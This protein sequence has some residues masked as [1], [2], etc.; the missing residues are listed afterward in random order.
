MWIFAKD[1]FL[2]ITPHREKPDCF[3]VRGR[4]KGDIEYYFPNADV[5]ETPEA[6]YRYR[7]TLLREE[8]ADRIRKAVADIHY[9][10]F[11]DSVTDKRRM[12][13]YLEVWSVM[14]DM[15]HALQSD[16]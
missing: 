13:F 9:R 15:Q 14:D 16:D 12:P 10:G 5:I 1:G 3:M 6:D 11:K 2:S 7:T 4:V 8:V